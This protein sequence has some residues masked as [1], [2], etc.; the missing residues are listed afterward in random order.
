[1]WL[2]KA[3]KKEEEK[4]ELTKSEKLK[5]FEEKKALLDSEVNKMRMESKEY[6][7]TKN[8]LITQAIKEGADVEDVINQN[9]PEQQKDANKAIPEDMIEKISTWTKIMQKS[10]LLLCIGAIMAM[11]VYAFTVTK[12]PNS[13]QQVKNM[14]VYMVLMGMLLFVMILINVGT[15]TGIEIWKRFIYKFKYRR[16]IYVNGLIAMK[17]GVYKRFFIKK[18][19][20]GEIRIN[21]KPYVPNPKLLFILDGVPSYLYREG[22]P[23]PMNIWETKLSNKFSCA[24]MDNVMYSAGV[25]DFKTWLQKNLMIFLIG[26]GATVLFAL[27]ATITGFMVYNML[28]KGQY[29]PT[30]VINGCKEI[31]GIISNQTISAIQTTNNGIPIPTPIGG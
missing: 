22:N 3:K 9:Q 13:T 24:E 31:F 14:V 10:V 26:V 17:S 30:P 5:L 12:N 23:D 18:E 15:M 16:G 20:T 19:D 4:K 21:A 29:D 8:D 7:A 11:I 27:T 1:M 25:F 28:K 2:F 6:I